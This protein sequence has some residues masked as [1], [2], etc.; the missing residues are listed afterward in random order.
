MTFNVPN[1]LCS[2][3]EPLVIDHFF[4][5]TFKNMSRVITDVFYVVE[6]TVNIF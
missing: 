3:I 6:K 4:L 2:V 5:D 1:N